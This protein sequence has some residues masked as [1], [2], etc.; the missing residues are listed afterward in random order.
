[1]AI[2]RS[3]T[4]EGAYDTLF[5]KG[6]NRNLD[7]GLK[8][9][10]EAQQTLTIKQLVI[11]NTF[12]PLVK[13]GDG[14]LTIGRLQIKDFGGD[15]INLQGHN[16][17]INQL[18]VRNNTST[19]PYYSLRVAAPTELNI[20][21][22]LQASKQQVYDWRLLQWLEVQENGQSFF[23][24]P[25][26]HN[27]IALQAYRPKQTVM[28][29]TLLQGGR[30]S[31]AANPALPMHIT[32]DQIQMLANSLF[33]VTLTTGSQARAPVSTTAVSRLLDWVADTPHNLEV[34]KNNRIQ[35]IDLM[36]P[37]NLPN[38]SKARLS[39]SPEDWEGISEVTIRELDIQT[40]DPNA[41]LFMLSEQQRYRNFKIG[42][43]KIALSCSYP[44]WFVANTL[45]NSVLGNANP[46]QVQINPGRST[47]A[48]VRI[49]D[50]QDNSQYCL[51]P[52]SC[53]TGEVTLVGLGKT[54]HAVPNTVRIL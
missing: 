8:I 4:S 12:L 44:W 36:V 39:A 46:N 31:D 22:A 52:S 5:I 26:Y 48:K 24:S 40:N 6:N 1:M 21:A 35:A 54:G 17:S 33:P 3:I 10:L 14:K 30:L 23:Y 42:T 9:H 18:I 50:G 16:L 49:G 43:D 11:E 51:K 13:S 2:I 29:R 34:D 38:A 41:Q 53:S 15:G 28:A 47:S 32:P 27:D 25:G 19:R 7:I 37:L 20:R 45:E